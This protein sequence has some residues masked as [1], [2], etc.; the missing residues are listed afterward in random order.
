M[1]TRLI[2]VR[3]GEAEGNIERIFHGWT[4]SSLTEKGRKQ[5]EKAAQRLKHED[6]KV[7]Y[8]SP[9]KRAYETAVLI[10]REQGIDD[11]RL[12]EGLKEIN[13]GEWENE[14]WEDLPQKWPE[15]YDTWERNPHLH[16]MPAGESMKEAFDRMAEAVYEIAKSH[17]GQNICIVTH[18]TVLRTLMCYF[19]G[20]PFEDLVTISWYDNTSITVVEFDST[21][22]KVA[23]EGDNSHLDDN[24][25]TFAGQDW[26]RKDKDRN[27][28]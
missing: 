26:W 16:C 5:A 27:N 21:Q 12:M 25:S 2:F 1:V 10:A 22:F 7:I 14:R 9:L 13:G 11:I 4:D 19:Y 24:L 28:I 15:E 17:E 3:H 20:K 8:S 6:I 18:G 23:L